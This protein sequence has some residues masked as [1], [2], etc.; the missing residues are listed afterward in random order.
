MKKKSGEKQWN[1]NKMKN[2]FFEK[3]IKIARQILM[4]LKW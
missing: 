4:T 1:I 3:T 2:W